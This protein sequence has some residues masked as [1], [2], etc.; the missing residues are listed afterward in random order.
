MN[1]TQQDLLLNETSE[2]DV[3]AALSLLRET[4]GTEQKRIYWEGSHYRSMKEFISKLDKADA[5]KSLP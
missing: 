1:A 2:G 5:A 3:V 4:L